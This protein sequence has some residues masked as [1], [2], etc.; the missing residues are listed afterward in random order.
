MKAVL[1]P[2]A[3]FAAAFLCACS[4]PSEEERPAPPPVPAVTDTAPVGEGIKTLAY[5]LLGASVVLTLGRLL[6]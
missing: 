6:R 4:G 2:V 5:A 3:A 1:P